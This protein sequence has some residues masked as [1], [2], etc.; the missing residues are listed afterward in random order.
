MKP[1]KLLLGKNKHKLGVNE[2][3]H[4]GLSLVNE[5]R[6]MPPTDYT[7]TIDAYETYFAEKDA[8]D[9]YRL[10]FT[11]NP[12]CSNVLFNV[13][14]EPVYKE[15]SDDA[16]V[17]LD[18]GATKDITGNMQKYQSWKFE[19]GYNP[20]KADYDRYALIHDTGY[21][22]KD[23]GPVEYHCGYDIFDNHYLRRKDGFFIINYAKKKEKLFQLDGKSGR[24]SVFNTIA[25]TL[26]NRS[27]DNVTDTIW[28]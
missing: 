21:S 15:G 20:I 25:D 9:K 28:V 2:N 3:N 18:N 7:A 14:T 24:Y 27:G 23:I 17:F 19:S 11:I 26:R 22:H 12:I 13:I 16:I 10:S 4:I 6:V 1:L 8:S 5:R